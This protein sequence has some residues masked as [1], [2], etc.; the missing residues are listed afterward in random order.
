MIKV[1][2]LATRKQVYVVWLHVGVSM[3]ARWCAY[4]R[5]V[6]ICVAYGVTEWL[7]CTVHYLEQ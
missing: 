3:C 6:R 1:L 4:V 5:G 2:E 7:G